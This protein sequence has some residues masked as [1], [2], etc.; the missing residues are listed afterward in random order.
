MLSLLW[1]QVQSLIE[2]L[3]SRKLCDATKTQRKQTQSQCVLRV[4]D[5][6]LPILPMCNSSY[7]ALVTAWL[8]GVGKYG[9]VRSRHI[10]AGPQGARAVIGAFFL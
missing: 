2:E 5:P 7:L 10:Q 1:T 3:R 4:S 6:C 9:P 8:Q